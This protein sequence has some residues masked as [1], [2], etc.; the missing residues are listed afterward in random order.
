MLGRLGV[1]AVAFVSVMVAFAASADAGS[2][3]KF[4]YYTYDPDY[5]FYYGPEYVPQPRY[6]RYLRDRP[7]YFYDEEDEGDYAYDPDYYEPEYIP[8]RKKRK[9]YAKPQIE[10]KPK[11][12]QAAQSQAN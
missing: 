9:S 3:W 1:I 12:K 5:D 8:P 11:K 4:R 10:T 7:A 6:Y 2:R